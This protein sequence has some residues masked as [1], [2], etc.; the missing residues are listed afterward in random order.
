[1]RSAARGGAGC[2]VSAYRT[3]G[4]KPKCGQCFAFARE[5]I[6]TERATA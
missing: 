1:V 3:L 6:A 5:I 4:R 2:P